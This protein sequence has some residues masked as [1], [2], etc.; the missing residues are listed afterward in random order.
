M[1]QADL[2]RI[3]EL[4]SSLS[5]A[6][7]G[8]GDVRL[9]ETDAERKN[10]FEN[11]RQSLRQSLALCQ[12]V[13]A[14]LTANVA[15]TD[16]IDNSQSSYGLKHVAENEIGEYVSN[17]VFIAAAIFAGYRYQLC[18]QGSLNAFFNM[19]VPV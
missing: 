8:A 15:K 10:R 14:W 18:R 6:G 13:V 16:A 5:F 9:N 17:G 1:N 2:D 11:D 19:A 12:R 3:L 4:E 7:F